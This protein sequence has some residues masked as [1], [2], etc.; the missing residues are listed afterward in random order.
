PTWRRGLCPATASP[1][2]EWWICPSASACTAHA[3]HGWLHAS[4]RW[5]LCATASS[6]RRRV[7][8]ASRRL[9]CATPATSADGRANR[10][11]ELQRGGHGH[12]KPG[13]VAGPLPV[14]RECAHEAQ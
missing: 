11:A 14:V 13:D 12:R 4:A 5:W 6:A 8:S 2:D 7:W 3:T 9:R 1:S 10:R